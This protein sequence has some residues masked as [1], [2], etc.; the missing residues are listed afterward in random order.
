MITLDGNFQQKRYAA[1]EEVAPFELEGENELWGSNALL[2]KYSKK[3][4]AAQEGKEVS[5]SLLNWPGLIYFVLYSV[6]WIL[7]SLK[8]AIKTIEGVGPMQ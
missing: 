5:L 8:Q 7:A 4:T 3:E 6:R 1:S 2:Q